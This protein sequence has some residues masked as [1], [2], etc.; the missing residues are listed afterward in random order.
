M[1]KATPFALFLL[2]LCLGL[3]S[4]PLRAQETAEV[5]ETDKIVDSIE[6]EFVDLKT[7]SREAVLARVQIREGMPYSQQLVDRSIR[8]LYST[9]LFDFIEATTEDISA[10]R[11][12]VTFR[13]KAKYRIEDIII[14]GAK[15]VSRSRLFRDFD[16]RV[17]GILDERRLQSDADKMLEVYQDK[18][19]TEAKVDF[20]ISRNPETGRGVVTFNIDEGP[21]LKIK[22]I[23]F[24]GNNEF[25]ARSLRGVMETKRRW[26]LSWLTGSGRFDEVVFQEDLEKLRA[27]YLEEGYL[28]VSIP[29]SGVTL[30]YPT[31]NQILITIQIDEGRQYKVGEVAFEGNEIFDNAALYSILRL[32]PGD[33]FS[34]EKLDEDVQALEDVYGSFGYLDAMARPDRRANV[35]TGNIDLVYRIREG[36]RFDVESIVIEG[37][38]KTKSTV[39]VRELALAPG[40]NFNLIY[41]KNSEA[42]LKNTR[43]FEDVQVSPE[44]SDIPGRRNLKIRVQEGRTGNLQFGAGFSS[45]E[46][47]V[48][49]F[50][51]SQSN[52]DLFKW[53][54]P[55]LQGDGQKFRLRGSI[56]SRSNEVSL[57]FEEPWLFEQRLAAGFELFRR[58]SDYN[59]SFYDELRT[60]IE[61][62]LRKRLFG[63]I[64]GQL[65]YGFQQIDLQN[66][67]S[68]APDVILYEGLIGPR[69]VSKVGF[70]IW[71][72]TRNNLIFTTRGSRFSFSTTFAGLGGNTE[73][74]KFETRNSL[75]IPL[76][77]TGDQVLQVIARA[78]TFWSYA[79]TD[80]PIY[81]RSTNAPDR[82][83]GYEGEVPFFERF[84]LGGPNS[85]RG[86]EYR[87]VSPIPVYNDG[88]LQ[89][90]PIGGNTYGFGSVEYTLEVAEPLRLALF[91]DWGFVNAD[92]FD[93]DPGSFNDNWGFGVRLQVLGN[94]LRL[95][96]GLPIT[97]SEVT[98]P[99]G[100]E[101]YTNNR[102]GQFNFSFG[103][104][105]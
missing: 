104:R 99:D 97:S 56:G 83:I 41:M 11:I 36:E 92:D 94:P 105:F 20:T 68:S 52:F 101:V 47:V 4:A 9:L 79:E 54:S 26:F 102:G 87:E 58:E 60:G 6:I 29:E 65:S 81:S 30:S 21:R 51:V 13:V 19:Y 23:E 98:N 18:G 71:R 40:R 34:P 48:V 33:T 45:I 72:D 55:I 69:T 25:S 39:I 91:Y 75:F 7:V 95:D 27:F 17:G 2:S 50:E 67:S 90:E 31:P 53:R 8:S 28:D 14:V 82:I 3:L 77:E 49:F 37:N 42:R 89:R 43:F 32:L 103:T 74:M 66:V 59:S 85:L 22:R 38:I 15:E 1:S 44:T 46:S 35:E 84:Y 62:F 76:F 96:Y 73:Y 61:L 12:K 24:I 64:D 10:N 100:T 70:D 86:F 80:R 63:L 57:Y 78:G 5:T 93:F 88:T 16:S